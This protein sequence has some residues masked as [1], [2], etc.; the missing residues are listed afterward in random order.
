MK[1]GSRL[2]AI[3]DGSKSVV[4]D[5]GFGLGDSL[6]FMASEHEDKLFLG[7][8][9]HRAGIAQCLSEVASRP[10][11]NVKLIRADATMLLASH[12]SRASVDEIHIYFPDP[13]PNSFR[14]G[15]RRVVR[16]RTVGLFQEVL[17][18]GGRVRIAT[19]VAEYAS[20]VTEVFAA[21]GHSFML[22]DKEVYQPCASSRLRVRGVTLY[23]QR[24]KEKGP[25]ERVHEF[26]YELKSA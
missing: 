7:C 10:L 12:L 2:G 25:G 21:A 26:L 5:I 18:P 20:H 6:V 8:E 9:I 4:L 1:Y 23:E 14:D 15:E 17:K 11:E 22:V 3:G 24:A 16:T 13:W 19:D